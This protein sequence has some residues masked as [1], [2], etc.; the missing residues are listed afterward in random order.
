ME[1]GF[2]TKEKLN[3]IVLFQNYPKT[4]VFDLLRFTFKVNLK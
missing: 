2:F 3:L 1:I 4:D